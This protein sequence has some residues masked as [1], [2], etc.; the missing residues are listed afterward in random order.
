[1]RVAY[2]CADPGVPVFGCKGASIHVQE[3]IRALRRRGASVEL[4]AARFGGDAPADLAALPCIGLPRPPKGLGPEREAAGI[5]AN[6]ALSAALSQRPAFDLVYERYSL[7]SFA[8]MAWA[9]EHG[10]PSVLE[11]NAPLVEEQAEHR[12]LHDRALAEQIAR[13]V[14]GEAGSILAVSSGVAA[15]LRSRGANTAAV[16]VVPNGVDPERFLLPRRPRP[17]GPFRIGFVGTLK[18]WHG[19]LT[20]IEAAAEARD[21]GLELRL[22]LV[23]DGPER[24]RVEAE[25]RNAGLAAVTELTGDVDPGRIP[26]LLANVDVATAPYPELP[27]FYF[28]PLK[29]MEYMAASKAIV[30]S[31]IG[32]IDGLIVDRVTGLLCPPGDAHALAEALVWLAGNPESGARMGEAAR[33]FAVQELSWNKVGERIIEMVRR[34]QLASAYVRSC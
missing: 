29:I 27:D 24:G 7:W 5:A 13:R 20:L 16:Q 17:D 21:K 32:D 6:E 14:F 8:G 9:R 12:V 19:L 18:P 33:R 25:L 30:A 3:V 28:S 26:T 23:G 11:V 31:R 34:Q 1:M 22:L 15:Y 2:I 4:F 10:C